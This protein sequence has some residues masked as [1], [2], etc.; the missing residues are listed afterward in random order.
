MLDAPLGGRGIGAAVR[1]AAERHDAVAA[2]PGG[3]DVVALD[4]ETVKVRVRHRKR[5]MR[6]R[7]AWGEAYVDTGCVCTQENGRWLHQAGSPRSC[8]GRLPRT[9]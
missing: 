8:G 9:P 4:S 7:L 3:V 6:E 5:Q 1:A 2:A